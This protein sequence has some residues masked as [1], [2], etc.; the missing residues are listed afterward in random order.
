M[1]KFSNLKYL[2][3]NN[4]GIDNIE[5]VYN[6]NAPNLLGLTLRHNYITKM[7]SLNKFR[8]CANDKN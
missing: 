3:L 7:K 1:I 6:M 5:F 4:L 8:R 2:G